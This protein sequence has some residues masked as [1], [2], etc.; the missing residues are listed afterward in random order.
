MDLRQGD[1]VLIDLRFHQSEGSKIRPVIV[2]LNSSDDDFVAVPVTSRLRAADFDVALA[3][4]QAV[5]L[6]VASF[7][8]VD[9]IAVLSKAKVRRTLG[10]LTEGDM[11][12][13]RQYLCR[14]YCPGRR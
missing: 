5:G 9:K 1:V 4:W 12:E 6:N 14:A 2:V 10:N 11:V 13:L 3:D 8:R 7:A